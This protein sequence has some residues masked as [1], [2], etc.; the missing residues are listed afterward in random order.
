MPRR[1]TAERT[2]ISGLVSRLRLPC[3]D[4]RVAGDEAHDSFPESAPIH[5]TVTAGR[6]WRRRQPF[7]VPPADGLCRLT[8][9]L[10]VTPLLDNGMCISEEVASCQGDR[11]IAGI[12][13][14]LAIGTPLGA[15]PVDDLLSGTA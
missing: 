10:T 3:M 8:G 13:G 15:L 2:A 11:N 14:C 7:A 4:L 1:C 9:A 5:R 6:R 12:G